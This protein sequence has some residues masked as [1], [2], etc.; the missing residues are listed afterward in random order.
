MANIILD[1]LLGDWAPS[2]LIG[3]VS[4][5]QVFAKADATDY[6]F[7]LAAPTAIGANTTV[8]LNTDLNEATGYQVFGF[9][10]GAEFNVNFDATGTP[11]LFSGGAGQTLVANNL[12][13][14]YSSDHTAIE[15]R[16]PKATIGNPIAVKT[17]YDFNDSQFLPISYSGNAITVWDDS[18]LVGIVPATDTKIAIVYSQ[19]SASQYFSVTAYS[20]LFMAAQSQAMQAGVSFD[21]LNESDLTDLA[22]LAQYKA[23]VFPDFRNVQSSQVDLIAHTLQLASQQFHVGLIVSGEFMTNDQNNQALPGNSY[24]RM[25]SLLDV[26]RVT[27]GFPADVTIHATDPGGLVLDGY[28]N[29]EL[30]NQYTGVGWNAFTSVSGT[31][32]T[33]A[34]ETIN[35]TTDYAAVIATQTG[36]RNVV[37]SSD[38]VMADVNLLQKAIDYSVNGSGVSVG[39]HITRDAGIVA[40]RVDMDQSKYLDAVNPTDG[41][42]GVYDLLLPLVTQWKQQYNF[43]GSYYLNIGNDPSQREGTDWAT[44]LPYFTALVQLG[45]ELGNHSYTHPFNTNVLTPAQMQFEFGTSTTVL[46]QQLSAALGY[47][48]QITGAAVPGSPETLQTALAIEQYVNTYM[49]GGYS[50]QGAGYPNAFG[51]LTPGSENKVYLAPN[52]FFDFTLF[53]FQHL[54]VAQA[55]AVWGAQYSKITDHG[56][57]PIVV[58]PWHDYGATGFEVTGYSTQVWN[59]YIARAAS[60]NMEFVTLGDLA[61]RINAFDAAKV[62]TSVS[63][64]TITANVTAGTGGAGNVGQFALDV[65]GQGSQVIKSVTNWYAYDSNSVFLPQSGGTFTITLGAAQDDVTHI[66]DLPMRASL[67]TLSGDGTNLNFTLSGEGLVVIDLTNPAG[68]QVNVTGATVVSQV[69]DLLT[70]DVGAIGT[71]AVSVTETLIGPVITSNGGGSTAAISIGENSTAVT[72]VIA[73]EIGNP[74]LTYSI[75]GTDAV[76]FAINAATGVLSFKTAPNFEAPTDAGRNNIYDLVVTASDGTLTDTQALA[77]TVTN[78]NE[79]P[80]ITSN[81]GGATAAI[82]RVENVKAVTTV[83]STDPEGT[84]RIYSISGTDAALFA[85]NAATGS[86]TFKNAPNYEAPADAGGNNIYDLVVTASDGTLTDTQALAVTVT[87]YNEAPVITSNP[88]GKASVAENTTAVTTVISTDPEGTPRTYSISGIDAALF[89]IDPT[90]GILNFITAPDY[91]NPTDVGHNNVYN[92]NVRASDGVL[93][94]SQALAVSVSN[95]SGISA[96]TSSTG[97]TLNGTGEED[98]LGGSS[99]ADVL[100][101]LGG[102]DSLTGRDGNDWLDGGAGNDLVFGGGGLDILTG[103]LGADKFLFTAISESRV[104]PAAHDIIMD[105]QPGIDLIDVSQIDADSIT[106]GNQ[107]FAFLAAPDA[108]FT[109]RGQ[110]AYHY[111]FIGGTEYTVI[112]GNVDAQLGADFEVALLGHQTL[113]SSMFVL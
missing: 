90:T 109:A 91:E 84:A 36:G 1:G 42:P 2:E 95:V 96:Q 67:L 21:L 113:A 54:T 58:W 63:G 93:T 52:T 12:Q 48:Y 62:T 69:G 98:T 97:G 18:A 46:Q 11:A 8:W 38:A 33:I 100:N 64:N 73:N 87:N 88:T 24:A 65:S 56:A 20:Q 70:L 34:T 29:G 77:V 104:G 112:Q 5:Y 68:K 57:T 4:G 23:I 72:T 9:T 45:S 13:F 106:A 35:G 39:L 59:D 99:A 37:F 83:T 103:G 17:L 7:A 55:A 19:T 66:T 16:I 105:F 102:N 94:T 60:Q 28:A 14:A 74:P 108:A 85:I 51:Y 53:E 47:N 44:S 79:A 78:V 111:E 71:H 89:T 43:V 6:I 110:V 75:A 32:Q 15:F 27:G 41:S 92:L 26:T 76:L 80:V 50:G 86:L 3:S 49:S 22:K 101:G 81:G 30:V 40:A 31:G 107:T 82:S 25:A 61:S 10:G